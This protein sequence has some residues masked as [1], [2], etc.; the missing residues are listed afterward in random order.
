LIGGSSDFMN[1]VVMFHTPSL[2]SNLKTK[3]LT[4]AASLQFDIFNALK[5]GSPVWTRFELLRL[6]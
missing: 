1:L 6:S 5:F 4:L 2:D 3:G